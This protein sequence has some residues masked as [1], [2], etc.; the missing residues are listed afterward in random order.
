M[1]AAEWG[2]SRPDG[3]FVYAD[4]FRAAREA[5]T[6]PNGVFAARVMGGTLDEMLAHLRRL[7]PAAARD[8]LAPLA[9]AFGPLRFVYLH[10]KDEVSQAVSR[11]RAE[12]TNVWS[13]TNDSPPVA[14][15]AVPTF[16]AER[17]GEYIRE[18]SGHNDAWRAWFHSAGAEPLVLV[19]E[20]LVADPVAITRSVLE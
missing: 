12:Q 7:Y 9:A 11:L 1:W 3:G 13:E 14:V 17:I 15:A 18:V 10:R 5:G 8:D 4:Y 2:I 16:D 6:T 19:Y 20:D